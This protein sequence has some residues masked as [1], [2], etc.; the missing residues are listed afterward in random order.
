MTRL[1]GPRLS[2]LLVSCPRPPC[3]GSSP[4]CFRQLVACTSFLNCRCTMKSPTC[5]TPPCGCAATARCHHPTQ[6]SVASH[7]KR[8][9]IGTQRQARPSPQ[10]Q[11]S[12]AYVACHPPHP[13]SHCPQ[14]LPTASQLILAP[15]QVCQ[16]CCQPPAPTSPLCLPSPYPWTCRSCWCQPTGQSWGRGR[17]AV[18]MW[19]D[20]PGAHGIG[21]GAP[22]AQ[23]PILL[24][25]SGRATATL[26]LLLQP[27]RVLNTSIVIWQ[28]PHAPSHLTQLHPPS[29]SALSIAA[30]PQLHSPLATP[31]PIASCVT[32]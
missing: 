17:R 15:R 31:M 1:C 7:S 3:Q 11:L 12:A 28:A 25:H 29:F 32:A 10:L 9:S 6:P 26:L 16:M 20:G 23:C 13:P 2:L 8:P 19:G 22:P 30:A 5:T 27:P 14:L 18:A 4:V 21:P 24:S